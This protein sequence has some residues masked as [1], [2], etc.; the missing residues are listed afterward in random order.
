MRKEEGLEAL[1]H[2]PRPDAQR[3]LG[4]EA[5]PALAAEHRLA[6]VG[7]GAGRG[8]AAD[9]ELAARRRQPAAMEKLLDPAVAQRLLS[10]RA[11]H[12]PAAGGRKL[13]RLR[14]VAERHAV[15]RQRRLDRRAGRA[16]AEARG[17]IRGVDR[18]QRQPAARA[19]C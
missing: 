7:P 19:R 10:R 17:Q 15:R 4:E 9:R 11:G 1:V 5:E 2:G 3:H 14:V 16:G 8:Q 18:L 12:D 6:Q 13:E